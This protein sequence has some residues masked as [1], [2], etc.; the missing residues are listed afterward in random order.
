VL[1]FED[2]QWAETTFVDL[3]LHMAKEST[4]WS[5][6]LICVARPEFIEAN[7]GGLPGGATQPLSRW[8]P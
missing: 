4:G 3:I 2:L 5:I 6:L 1:V 8:S 7:R